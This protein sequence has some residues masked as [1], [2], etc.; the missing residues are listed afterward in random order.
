MKSST[1]GWTFSRTGGVDQVVLRDGNDIERLKNL[2]PKLWAVLA[3]PADQPEY[4]E[5]LRI[6]DTDKDSKVRVPE[7]LRCVEE[8]KVKLASLDQLFEP[9]D[10]LPFDQIMDPSAKA[11][12][13]HLLESNPQMAP[14]GRISLGE[15]D[16]AIAVFSSLPFN[17]DG[18]LDPACLEDGAMAALA[19]RI[20]AAGFS[21]G[22][23]AGAQGLA[24][25][26]LAAFVEA[27]KSRIAWLSAEPSSEAFTV[28]A[29]DRAKAYALFSKLA[30]RMDDYFQRCRV[31]AM[32]G[33]EEVGAELG[34]V[35]S[36]IVAGGIEAGGGAELERLP[37]AMPK[38]SALLSSTGAINPRDADDIAAFMAL[39]AE[40][41][42]L[43]PDLSQSAW[44]TMKKAF[45]AY[46]DWV[47]AEPFSNLAGFG[48][49]ELESLLGGPE[50][51]ALGVL[52]EKDAAMAAKGEGLRA[53]RKLIV[54]KRD[55]L[56]VLRNFV[57]F[58]DFYSRGNGLFRAG[59]LFLDGRELEFCLEVKNAA[60]HAA[61]AGLSSMYLIYCTLTSRGGQQK[62]IVAALTAGDA[63]NIF[64]GR[65]GVFYDSLGTDW[66]A[67]ITK[68]VVQ[69]ISIREAFFSPYKWFAKSLGDFA[70]KRAATAEAANM[71]KLKT[72][73]STTANV[74]K[75]QGKPELAG[76]PKKIDVGTVAAIGVALGSI[77]AMVT[78][79]LGLFFGLGAW[80]PLGFAGVLLLISGPSMILAYMKLRKRNIGPLLNAE[81]WAING[82]LKI[83][84]P[85]GAT[86]SH[87]SALPEGSI[88]H[89]VDPFAEK[90]RPWWLYIVIVAVIGAVV[91]VYFLGGFNPLIGR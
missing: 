73:A 69:P 78:S 44:E 54:M 2:D 86:L 9:G 57:N 33:S 21:A 50:L 16:E 83:N 41:F 49:E 65:N 80:M 32:A 34:K 58:D 8:L 55:F 90:K 13:V 68:V 37:I 6:L 42:G 24:A 22:D 43:V 12:V 29:A 31:I 4:G 91:A 70:M 17:G 60:N 39:V 67:V 5:A 15:V 89:I 88:R 51:A 66:D 82:R 14:S 72:A 56:G 35:L 10:S 46:G 20:I 75:M 40:P 64:V 61:M 52:I 36:A 18:V 19:E 59:R 81:G 30:P 7:I 25:D 71:D 87:L 76:L 11:A 74:D 3:M 23:S 63:D 85:F 28:Q 45:V 77:G 38:A 27:A 79:I 26:S 62:S 53:L 84:V 47:G 48:G 1:T